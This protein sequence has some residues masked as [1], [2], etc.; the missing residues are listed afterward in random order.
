MRT[1]PTAATAAT[2][3]A[4]APTAEFV[5]VPSKQAVN[6]FNTFYGLAL[7]TLVIL[8]IPIFYKMG[9]VLGLGW[10]WFKT[11]PNFLSMNTPDSVLR[12]WHVKDKQ[13]GI[14]TKKGFC[15]IGTVKGDSFI[16]RGF[17]I[18][19]LKFSLKDSSKN[20]SKSSS[21]RSSKKKGVQTMR[22]KQ[23]T[24]RMTRTLTL[25]IARDSLSEFEYR[26]LYM[27]L[28]FH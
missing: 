15:A 13:F 22:V 11:L 2:P 21:P 7:V 6:F 16:S 5:F 1:G 24:Y 8:H 14:E 4:T 9:L 27:R 20:S 3:P 23:N 12:L 10:H 19:R 26:I 17:I 28:L 18:L 25:F